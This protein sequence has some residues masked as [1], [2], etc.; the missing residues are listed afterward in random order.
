VLRRLGP[1]GNDISSTVITTFRYVGP[2]ELSENAMSIPLHDDAADLRRLA[3]LVDRVAVGDAP[4]EVMA[5]ALQSL[6]RLVPSDLAA[7]LRLV[8]PTV[9]R[10]VAAAGPLATESVRG[11]E[12]D[13]ARMPSVR[14]VLEDR[15]PRAFLDHDHEAEGDPYDGVLDLP[16][17]HSC[18]VVPLYAGSRALG[19]IT[20]DR[21]QCGV[22]SDAQVELAGIVGQLVSMAL[23]FAEQARLL[24]RYRHQLQEHNRLLTVAAGGD[25]VA[26][27]RLERSRSEAMR[28]L[29]A[30]APQVAASGLP[31]LVQG[32]TG[33]GKEVLA[34]ALH[35][36]SPRVDGPFVQLNCAAIPADLVESEL[37][38]HVRG[39]FSGATRD[40]PGRFRTANGGTLLL[41]EVGE[42]SAGVQAKLLRV[43]QEGCFEPVGSDRTVRVDV[44]VI[45]ATHVDLQQAV[46]QGRFRED[47][48]YRL[49]VFP[50][51]MP[52]LRERVDD[53]VPIAESVLAERANAGRGPWTLSAEARAALE[54][55][56]WP[57]NVRELINVLER[58]MVLCPRGELQPRHL[59]LGGRRTEPERALPTFEQQ[60]RAYLQRLLEATGGKLYGDDG[61]AARAGLKPTTLRSKL[62]KHGLR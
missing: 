19:C 14:R 4:D 23:V 26:V 45:A 33:T 2:N 40:R 41:D 20:L 58:A 17:G 62:V 8:E 57:G 31:V 55:S 3:D 22:Y 29:V 43:L 42:L 21:A 36:W 53:I 13:L 27:R 56:P 32:E 59:A 44:R 9:M 28:E 34:A 25:Q 5:R 16:D 15:R 60:E 54:G 61:A 48:Y 39:A 30:V 47:L 6:Q 10:V 7:V 38:G 46:A 37:F 11:H 49:A 1:C 18:M 52:P 50:L 51:T 35:A 24:D 12:V